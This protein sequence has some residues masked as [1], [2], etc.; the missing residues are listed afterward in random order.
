MAPRLHGA[1]FVIAQPLK[2]SY[3]SVC[4]L[5]MRNTSLVSRYMT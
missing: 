2:N 4:N 3:I 1:I 5:Q